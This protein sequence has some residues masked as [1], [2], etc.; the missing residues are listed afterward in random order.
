MISEDPQ[1]DIRSRLE[2]LTPERR[3]ELVRQLKERGRATLRRRPPGSP[4][5]LS[6]EQERLWLLDQL[7]PGLTA[8]NASRVLRLVGPLDVAIL[9]RA[10]DAVVARHD[11]LRTQVRSVDGEASPSIGLPRPVSLE[12]APIAGGTIRSLDDAVTRIQQFLVQSFDLS[13]DLLLR[14]L[15]VELGPDDHVLALNVHH[16]AS[17]G[18]SR[19]LLLDELAA[20]YVGFATGADEP[21]L[22]APRFQFSDVAAWQRSALS[23]DRLDAAREFW[24]GY[25]AGAPPTIDLPFDRPRPPAQR[26]LRRCRRFLRRAR[27]ES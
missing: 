12:L 26:D 7:T 9:Q 27:F 17:D 16:I 8:Y 11:V 18:A 14:G 21:I 23:D 5:V 20:H 13:S 24:V 10:L 15:L 19:Q 2:D 6:Y 4:P 1:P 25:L 3:A 22:E